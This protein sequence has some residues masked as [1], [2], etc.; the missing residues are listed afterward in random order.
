MVLGIVRGQEPHKGKLSLPGGFLNVGIETIEACAA[1]ELMEET[2]LCRPLNTFCP[3]VVQSNPN[4]DPRGHVID[5]VYSVVVTKRQLR[6][7]VAGDDAAKIE[8]KVISSNDYFN[9]SY[10]YDTQGN[11]A[12]GAWTDDW[13]FDHGISL[14]RFL[15]KNR[16]FDAYYD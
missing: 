13:A 9:S 14:Y 7:A 5:H 4:R 12:G 8:F 2:G 6:S 16:I 15:Q 3:V 11:L 1:R 10:R